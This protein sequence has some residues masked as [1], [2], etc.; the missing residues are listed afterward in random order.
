[1]KNTNQLIAIST[2]LVASLIGTS[3]Q[4]GETMTEVKSGLSFSGGAVAGLIA[5]GPV[6]M[7][8]GALG[9]V[10]VAEQM[11]MAE[12]LPATEQSLHAAKVDIDLLEDALQR[13]Q[14]QIALLENELRAEVAANDATRLEFQL[15]FR[16]GEDEI[17]D[18]DQTRIAMLAS[19][20]ER[21]PDL[22]VRLDGHADPRGSEEY[23]N[24]LAKFRALSVANALFAQGID[25]DRVEVN[26]HGSAQS[27]ANSG[28]YE[29]YAL[30]RRVNIEVYKQ[31]TQNLAQSR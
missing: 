12:E 5:G 26:F 25:E 17:Q 24:I 15:M 29:S 9:G 14:A 11:K 22:V 30:E 16:T 2:L 1:M 23:N 18:E 27:E 4:A 7:F 6:G 8:V 13:E 10:Y 20:L 21:N 28:D 19:Y 3:V 31:A